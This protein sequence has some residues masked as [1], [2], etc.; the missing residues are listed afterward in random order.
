MV[1]TTRVREPANETLESIACD[2]L[3]RWRRP[4]VRAHCPDL[5]S[6]GPVE[7]DP[8]FLRLGPGESPVKLFWN[9]FHFSERPVSGYLRLR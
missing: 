2:A 6:E 1:E 9:R 5:C 4:G 8:I 7:I 3:D